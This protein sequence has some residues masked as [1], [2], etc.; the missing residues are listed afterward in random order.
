MDDGSLRFKFVAPR[1]NGSMLSRD[2][3]GCGT[4]L[5]ID[6]MPDIAQS[7]GNIAASNYHAA[8]RRTKSK[9]EVTW[10]VAEK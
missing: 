7:R 5:D 8:K 9:Q 6:L 3:T 4:V 1:E 10:Q 2:L